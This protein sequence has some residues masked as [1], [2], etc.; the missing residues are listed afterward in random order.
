VC[1]SVSVCLSVCCQGFDDGVGNLL[2]SSLCQFP[3]ASDQ[4][5]SLCLSVYVCLSLYV[6]LCLCLSVCLC[7]CLSVCC[8]GFDD[9]V[10]S[11]LQS[12]L[13]QFPL[14]FDQPLSLLI[15]LSKAGRESA[16]Q[17]CHLHLS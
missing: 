2:Q 12:S 8:Q 1:V 11:L 14:S 9:G 4:P 5:L 13:C 15:A 7:M 16:L 10:G 6:C 17:V 3:L